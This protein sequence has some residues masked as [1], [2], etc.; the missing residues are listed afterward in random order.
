MYPPVRVPAEPRPYLEV[1]GYTALWVTP[2]TNDDAP[3]RMTETVRLRWA[4]LRIDANPTRHLHV[5][6]R[7]GFMADPALLDASVTWS[8][9]APL[10]ITFGQFRMPFGAAGTTLAPQLVML[11]RPSFSETGDSRVGGEVSVRATLAF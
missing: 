1:H 9:L 10:N 11:D 6:M 5:L 2:V 8:A 7:L 4:V 3:Q